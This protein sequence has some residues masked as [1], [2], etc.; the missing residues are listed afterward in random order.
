MHEQNRFAL[1]CSQHVALIRAHH[2][3]VLLQNLCLKSCSSTFDY[4]IFVV[5]HI[6][7]NKNRGERKETKKERKKPLRLL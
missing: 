2:V 3:N 4:S 7:R 5:N 6:F 1:R